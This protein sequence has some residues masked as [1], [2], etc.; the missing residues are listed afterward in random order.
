MEVPFNDLSRIHKDLGSRF[1]QVLDEVLIS[2]TYIGGTHVE[3]FEKKFSS[4][5]GSDYCVSC[6]NGTDALQIAIQV[7]DL[8]KGSEVIVPA[9][10]WVS[11]AEAVIEQGHIPVLCDTNKEYLI[12][13]TRIEELITDRTAA[14]IP[15]HLAGHACDMVKIKDIANKYSLKLIE[16]CAQA[17]GTKFRGKHVGLFA[18]I[19]TFSFY[20]GKSLGA[21]GDAGCLVTN[22]TH[23]ATKAKL[24]KDHGGKGTHLVSGINSRLDSLQ[25]AFLDVKLDFIEKW[26]QEKASLAKR[27]DV[28]LRS[29]DAPIKLPALG[30]STTVPSWHL[31]IIQTS[32]RDQLVKHLANNGVQTNINYRL[33]LSSLP[34][35]S[36]YSRYRCI[37][38]E[39]ACAQI[40]SLPIFPGMELDEVD[41]VCDM[42][43]VFMD[44]NK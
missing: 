29:L 18:D 41:F 16:D 20:P 44:M 10:T 5:V 25:A 38:A 39:E 19:A 1:H 17:H 3:M 4:F 35:F 21:L 36:P 7:L 34:A 23:L 24:Y 22:N 33:P 12:D 6:A 9:H 8:P 43:G 2:S 11:T 30:T 14:I 27:Y 40:V 31:Y 26:Q 37:N 15:V 28:R 42:I 32:N 13:V